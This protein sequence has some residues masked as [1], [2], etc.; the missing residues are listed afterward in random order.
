MKAM[1]KASPS[2][3]L[4]DAGNTQVKCATARPR[5]PIRTVSRQATNA[6]TSTWVRALARKFP[7]HH[8]VLSSVVP[9]MIPLF[10]RAFAKRL[11]VVTGDSPELG[12]RFDYP[13]PAELGADRL[14]AAVA[15]HAREKW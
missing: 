14:A 9:R 3:L 6:V 4:I 11:Q 5:G 7:R 8:A 10:Q 2:F 1:S 13:K 15:A 12:L